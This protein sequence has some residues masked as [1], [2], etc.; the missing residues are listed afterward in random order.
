MTTMDSMKPQ[1]PYQPIENH[2][3]GENTIMSKTVHSCQTM[4]RDANT[5]RQYVYNM[6]NEHT[7][8][9]L[10]LMELERLG[11]RPPLC[12]WKMSLIP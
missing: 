4:Y 10:F 11:I 2:H 12:I 6:R 7:L 5:I 9:G 8:R 3:R 1:H